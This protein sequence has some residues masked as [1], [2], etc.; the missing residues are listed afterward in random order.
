MDFSS[1]SRR[2]LQV[3]CKKNKIPA[4]MTNLAMADALA[5]LQ[6]VEGLEVCTESNTEKLM[7]TDLCRTPGVARTATRMSTRRKPCKEIQEP[8]STVTRSCRST[9]KV[10]GEKSIQVDDDKDK[11][12]EIVPKEEQVMPGKQKKPLSQKVY[13]TRRSVRLLDKTMAGLTLKDDKTVEPI[14]MN[15]LDMETAANHVTNAQIVSTLVLEGTNVDANSIQNHSAAPKNEK[16][17]EDEKEEIAAIDNSILGSDAKDNVQMNEV[18]METVANGVNTSHVLEKAHDGANSVQNHSALPEN[19]SGVE[20]EKVDNAEIQNSML[21]SDAKDNVQMNEMDMETAANDANIAQSVSTHVGSVQ[22]HSAVPENEAEVE[23]QKEEN[24]DA[25][26]NVQGDYLGTNMTENAYIGGSSSVSVE[27]VPCLPSSNA[28]GND[29]EADY[30]VNMIENAEMDSSS[31]MSDTKDND[32]E[33][34]LSHSDNGHEADHLVNNMIKTETGLGDL[35]AVKF[36]DGS[37][38]MSAGVVPCLPSSAAK[39]SD[40]EADYLVNNMIENAEMESSSNMSAGVE[41][42]LSDSDATDSGHEQVNNM[43][44]TETDKM[45]DGSSTEVL[46]ENASEISAVRTSESAPVFENQFGVLSSLSQVEGSECPLGEILGITQDG[47]NETI[48]QNVLVEV[49]S[50][51][52]GQEL[53]SLDLPMDVVCNFDQQPTNSISVVDESG[54]AEIH[55]TQTVESVY[56]A[57]PSDSLIE[58]GK[59]AV[60][61]P[62][63]MMPGVKTQDFQLMPTVESAK[64]SDEFPQSLAKTPVSFN[65]T[66]AFSL[67]RSGKSSKKNPLERVV[68]Y[69]NKENIISTLR[70]EPNIEKVKKFQ[71][72]MDEDN[73][74]LTPL[75]DKSLRQLTKMLKEKLQIANDCNDASMKQQQLGKMRQALQALPDNCMTVT[76][77]G[78]N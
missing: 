65:R 46:E 31:D 78:D 9:R 47:I 30:L 20:D 37:S 69:E 22:N 25:N 28:K 4:N 27:V 7:D 15:E 49:P 62:E 34:T 50:L 26:D 44:E 77:T 17:V 19:E 33:P 35:Y 5:T 66:N 60:T 40:H 74:M 14:K 1:L 3:L 63:W 59:F 12:N 58:A 10:P 42:T 51:P 64:E 57:P 29:H 41:P 71:T 73:S 13:S 18:D 36:G 70:A 23:D 6:Q 75:N 39:D 24:A 32:Y 16:G 2:E 56:Q 55:V 45:G 43:I 53:D 48:P 68:S 54:P 38:S 67:C 11:M 72:G 76:K 21:G 8:Q 61:D 52:G